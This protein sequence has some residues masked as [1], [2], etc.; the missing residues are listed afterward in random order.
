MQT[1]QVVTRVQNPF[2]PAVVANGAVSSSDFSTPRSDNPIAM[3]EQARAIAEVQAAMVV[4]RANPR[5]K[6]QAMDRILNDCS[7]LGLAEKAVYAYAKGG[8]AISG[9]SIRLAECIAQNWGNVQYGIRELSQRNGVSTAL[10]YAWDVETNTKREVQF[11]VPLKRD[12]KKGSYPITDSRE[13]YELVANFGARRLRSCILSL[14]PGDVIE[15]AVKQCEITIKVNADVSQEG[16]ENLLNAFADFGVTRQQIEKRI[17]RRIESINATQ[18][19]ML[20]KI[21]ASLRDEMSSVDDWF[22]PLEEKKEAEATP[23]QD[24]TSTATTGNSGLKTKLKKSAPKKAEAAAP[25]QTAPQPE[26][27]AVEQKTESEP[28]AEWIKL[29]TEALNSCKSLE[30]FEDIWRRLSKKEQDALALV[31]DKKFNTLPLR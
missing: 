1:T 20:R 8:T 23:A 31:A 9:P 29:Q 15:E 26:K 6:I 30:E 10:A 4:A 28:S 13:V 14:I 16:I 11:Q 12:T 27:K 25:E 17:Q 2:A 18:V 5:N 24:N 3:N 22:E 7:R 21:Y 19:L